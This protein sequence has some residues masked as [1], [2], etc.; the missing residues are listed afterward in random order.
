MQSCFGFY[1]KFFGQKIPIFSTPIF[2]KYSHIFS[3]FNQ[4]FPTSIYIPYISEWS[5]V[6]KKVKMPIFREKIF[7]LCISRSGSRRTV[8][9]SIMIDFRNKLPF[10]HFARFLNLKSPITALVYPR[11]RSPIPDDFSLTPNP[12]LDPRLFTNPRNPICRPAYSRSVIF[13][14]MTNR[15]DHISETT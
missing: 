12:N 15:R 5:K 11:P 13:L 3:H 14:S 4:L 1:V 7:E 9:G 10:F 8:A 2:I 6:K